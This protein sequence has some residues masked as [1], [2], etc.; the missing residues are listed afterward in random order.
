MDY[1]K[2]SESTESSQRIFAN[3]EIDFFRVKIY[4]S[5]LRIESAP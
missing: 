4:F 1:P 5:L 3:R 2:F